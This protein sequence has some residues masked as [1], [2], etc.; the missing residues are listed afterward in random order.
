MGGSRER[1]RV[2]LLHCT[3]FLRTFPVQGLEHR[4]VWSHSLSLFLGFSK[5]PSENQGLEP[6][7]FRVNFI[8]LALVTLQ[9]GS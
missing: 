6:N 5:L 2:L 8:P 7:Q 4:R 9:T 3:V 1:H